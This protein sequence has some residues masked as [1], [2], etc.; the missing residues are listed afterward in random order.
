MCVC[1]WQTPIIPPGYEPYYKEGEHNFQQPQPSSSLDNHQYLREMHPRGGGFAIFMAFHQ[2]QLRYGADFR[3][4][5][6]KDDLLKIDQQ[7]CDTSMEPDWFAQS[8]G[9]WQSINSLEKYQFAKRHKGN[10]GQKD[11][12]YI[13]D[14]GAKFL[15]KMLQKY[16][17]GDQAD[18]AD[19]VWCTCFLGC[20]RVFWPGTLL[21][22]VI[23]D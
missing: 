8:A 3:G 19:Q 17:Q 12:F 10:R 11:E 14:N 22:L 9:A 7:Y 2:Q 6:H 18:Q 1:V 13:T 15:G 23:D 20:V 5:L 21:C 4:P 16:P